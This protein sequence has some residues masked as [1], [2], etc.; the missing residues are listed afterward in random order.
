[1]AADT[2]GSQDQ[3]WTLPE[4]WCWVPLKAI[5]SFIGRGRG[6]S[7]VE[8][9]GVPVVNQKCVR[10]H[11]LDVQHL[12]LTARD[13]FDRLS[14]EL[15]LRRG[16]LLWNSTGT[17]TIGRATVYDGSIEELTADS[18]VTIVRPVEI[19]PRYLGYFVETGRVQHLVDEGH[20]GST[21]QREL[22]RAFVEELLLPIAPFAEQ[23]RIVERIDT[24]FA[25]IANGEAALEDARK[26]LETFRRAVLKSAVTGELTRDWRENNQPNETGH[27]L[28]A[29]I[30]AERD[31]TPNR[32]AAKGCGKPAARHIG[33][34][35][36]TGGLG[37]GNP[38]RSRFI[39]KKWD[40]CGATSKQ[41]RT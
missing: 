34:A 2:S 32:D 16:D 41:E 18:H 19:D 6:P 9:N 4:G 31:A 5:T 14:P 28:L 26:G 39:R 36:T 30:K 23:R 15:R 21:N 8:K 3:P 7:Y 35:G 40:F 20:V 10:W 33:L 22:P 37:L 17:G 1:M 25:E 12:R 13:A 27:D 38:R 11:R 24:L 29:R